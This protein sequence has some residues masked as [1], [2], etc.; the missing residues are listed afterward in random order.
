MNTGQELLKEFITKHSHDA[1]ELVEQL[2][3]DEKRALINNLPIHLSVILVKAMEPLSVI[4]CF[5]LL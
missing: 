3:T 1:A 5:D 2:K 4:S